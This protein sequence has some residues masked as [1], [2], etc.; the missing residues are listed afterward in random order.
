[1]M[2]LPV[3]SQSLVQQAKFSSLTFPQAYKCLMI[4]DSGT[5]ESGLGDIRRVPDERDNVAR[6]APACNEEFE[7]SKWKKFYTN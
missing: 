3:P 7:V 6:P 4:D 1:M 5:G 2:T